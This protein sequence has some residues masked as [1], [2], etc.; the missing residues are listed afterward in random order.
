MNCKFVIPK[1][2]NCEFGDHIF[3]INTEIDRLY[4]EFV[5]PKFTISEF[6]DHKFAMYCLL[7]DV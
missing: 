2:G 1:F 7:T 6:G 5:I 4:C 3:A